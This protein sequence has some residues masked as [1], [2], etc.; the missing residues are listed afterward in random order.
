MGILGSGWRFGARAM[1]PH[2]RTCA[3]VASLPEA[4]NAHP[5]RV[6]KVL[7]AVCVYLHPARLSSLQRRPVRDLPAATI[8]RRPAFRGARSLPESVSRSHYKAGV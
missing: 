8:A 6:P 3:C 5:G 4:L 2:A 1:E 7:C